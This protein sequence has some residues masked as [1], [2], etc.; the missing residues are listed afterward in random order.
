MSNSLWLRAP[1]EGAK[2]STGTPVLAT[3]ISV[4]YPGDRQVLRRLR[5]EV[6]PGEYV[7]LVGE[8]GAGK[9]TLALAIL[10][11][12]GHLGGAVSGRIL[13]LGRDLMRCD[14]RRMRDIRG[15]QVSLIPQS[16]ASAL[17]PALRLETQL[18]EAW[19]AHSSEEWRAQRERIGSLLDAAGLPGEHGFLR[20]FPGEISV[21]QAQRVLIVMAL[22][23]GP[24]LL[25]A[26]EPTS[27]LD[28]ITQRDVL[29]LL[30]RI[31]RE[32]Q[33][34]ILFISHD[35][36]TVAALC[37]RIAILHG[38]E[39][40]ESGPTMEVLK[41]PRHPYTKRLIEAVPKW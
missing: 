21:G 7:G 10:R 12:L 34:S 3:D 35:L 1:L 39:I 8:S 13:L 5:I 40:V 25:I 17:S 30:G 29:E 36:P 15:R 41:E 28:V 6:F 18:R 38:G 26:D 11:L 16:P 37:S 20:K 32:R 33:M 27:A 22:L 14:E 4:G 9:S 31:G 2:I 19:R 24:A 23:H